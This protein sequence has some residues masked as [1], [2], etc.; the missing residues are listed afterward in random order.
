[1]N[2]TIKSFALV[3]TIVSFFVATVATAD[4]LSLTVR[5]TDA[6]A[7][8]R[9]LGTCDSG[10]ALRNEA[11]GGSRLVPFRSGEATLTSRYSGLVDPRFYCAGERRGMPT[12]GVSVELH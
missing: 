7:V 5:I 2:T 10:F 12:N 1:M 11:D 8:E 3:L 9:E 4:T 6:S